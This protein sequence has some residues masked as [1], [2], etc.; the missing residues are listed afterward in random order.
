[1]IIETK[2]LQ[3]YPL[4]IEVGDDLNLSAKYHK[5]LSFNFIKAEIIRYKRS[6]HTTKIIE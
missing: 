4:V 5:D 2:F 1:M 3:N 6:K